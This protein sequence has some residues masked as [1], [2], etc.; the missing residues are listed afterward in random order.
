M[1]VRRGSARALLVLFGMK[2]LTGQRFGK[3]T[4]IGFAEMRKRHSYWLCRCDC[5][6][7]REIQRNAVYSL[8]SCGCD[9]PS[10]AR[11]VRAARSKGRHPKLRISGSAHWSWVAMRQRC[12]NPNHKNWK[13]YGGRGIRICERWN[14]YAAF[15]E[16][17]GAR[18][19]GKTLDRYPNPDGNYEPG[20]CRWATPTEQARN[21][22]RNLRLT[23]NGVRLTAVE[24]EELREFPDGTLHRRKRAGWSDERALSTPSRKMKQVARCASHGPLTLGDKTLSLS[25]IARRSGK[26]RGL[27]WYR[28]Y[29]LGWSLPAAIITPDTPTL[30]RLARYEEDWKYFYETL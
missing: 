23:L 18:P 1:S 17:M 28:I 13:H 5:G 27:L 24:W 21:M 6:T 22:R 15:L 9:K 19:V 3:W 11:P 30:R 12:T 29:K 14:S 4:V 26:S 7:E 10:E 16:D 2:D 20:N 8:Q 25:E